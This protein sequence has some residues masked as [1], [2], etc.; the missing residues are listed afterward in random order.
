MEKE[1][2]VKTK[3]YSIEEKSQKRLKG[4]SKFISVLA[5]IGKIFLIIGIVGLLI[6]MIAVPIVSS[7]TKVTKGEEE[8]VITVFDHDIY[9]RRSDLK[10]EIYDKEDLDNK[11]VVTNKSEVEKINQVFDYLEKNDFT[12]ATIFI[13]VEL[14]LFV[15]ILVV[16]V[17]V[18]KKTEKFFKNIYDKTTPF[19][20]E[21]L[22][23]MKETGKLLIIALIISLVSDIIAV[24][25][26]GSSAT[27]SV[28]SITEI[29]TVYFGLYIF[30]Y[31]CKLQ[32]ETKGKIYSE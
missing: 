18:F 7:N 11:Q 32:N 28:V 24:I 13:E 2:E 16:Q 3:D 15:A 22:E 4:I 23:L 17:I 25:V 14:A 10:F 27:I 9:Y 20:K 29:L 26:V 21:N 6:A 19:I 12:A 31:G 8:S 5:K 30:E 1:K